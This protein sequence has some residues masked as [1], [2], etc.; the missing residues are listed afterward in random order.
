MNLAFVLIVLKSLTLGAYASPQSEYYDFDS[1]NTLSGYELKSALKQILR[2]THTARSYGSLNQ[3]YLESDVDKTYENDGSIVDMYSENAKA[4][5]Q[6]NYSKRSHQCGNY[7]KEG[8]CANRE[9]L[10]PQ[11]IF[12][13][14]SPMRSDFFHVFPTDGY[15][16]NRRG[17]LPFGEVDNPE[18]V[19]ANGSKVGTNCSGPYRGKVFEPIDE[20]KGDIAR[21]LLYFAIRY[22][23]RVANWE[24]DMIDNT[25]DQVYS[26]WF[27][28]IL[29]KWHKADP[30]SA[31]ELRRNEVGFTYQN[32]RNPLIDYPQW[33]DAIWIQG[34]KQQRKRQETRQGPKRKQQNRQRGR[35]S[36][37]R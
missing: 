6:Y 15:V 37:R 30:V 27:L 18:W 25:R 28:D 35:R 3:I 11:S 24:H 19:S 10:F 36:Q 31:H 22:E 29:I 13:K 20:F 26:K 7:R 23:D 17:R 34:Q 33:V 8:D 9:H 4:P 32:N 12:R 5:D 16:N 21:A 14:Q 2:Q 1:I